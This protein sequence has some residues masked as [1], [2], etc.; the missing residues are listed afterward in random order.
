MKCFDGYRLCCMRE[1]AIS[2][3]SIQNMTDTLLPLWDTSITPTLTSLTD[4]YPCTPPDDDNILLLSPSS[5]YDMPELIL[6]DAVPSPS[7]PETVWHITPR[8]TRQHSNTLKRKLTYTEDKIVR[9]GASIT[10]VREEHDGGRVCVFRTVKPVG[11][12]IE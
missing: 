7:S 9:L 12:A 2:Q 10:G 6:E 8:P 3:N 1:P 11:C 4:L 5:P